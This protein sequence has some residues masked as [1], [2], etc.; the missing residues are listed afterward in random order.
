MVFSLLM[1]GRKRLLNLGGKTDCMTA[2]E[3]VYVLGGGGGGA[4]GGGG[5]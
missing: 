1:R 2:V 5:V 3:C 4:G